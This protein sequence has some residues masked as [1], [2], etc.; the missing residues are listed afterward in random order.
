MSSN[1]V[2]RMGQ[3]VEVPQKQQRLVLASNKQLTDGRA[4]QCCNTQGQ[5]SPCL[6]CPLITIHI[7]VLARAMR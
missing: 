3:K 7:I 6:A 5:A 4:V 2:R 1:P